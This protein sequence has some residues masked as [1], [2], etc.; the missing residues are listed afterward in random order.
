MLQ[1]LAMLYSVLEFRLFNFYNDNIKKKTGAKLVLIKPSFQLNI[2]GFCLLDDAFVCYLV[3][4]KGRAGTGWIFFEVHLI[5]LSSV[6][7]SALL[8]F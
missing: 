8:L 3:G 7:Y 6:D 1:Y 2:E 4:A 5:G